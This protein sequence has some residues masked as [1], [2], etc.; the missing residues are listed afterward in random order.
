MLGNEPFPVPMLPPHRRHILD[1]NVLR[2]RHKGVDEHR[3]DSHQHSKENEDAELELAK[4]AEKDLGDYKCEQH[5]D[6]NRQTLRRRSDFKR[7]NFAGNQP[8]QRSP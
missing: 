7:E 2:L 5:I 3:H 6:G 1:R 4:H 8:A